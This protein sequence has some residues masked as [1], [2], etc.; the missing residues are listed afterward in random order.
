MS[1]ER[2][3][4]LVATLNLP[5]DQSHQLQ[6]KLQ[7]RFFL[8]LVDSVDNGIIAKIGVQRH[9]RKV[10]ERNIVSDSR[11]DSTNWNRVIVYKYRT[12]SSLLF[13][14]YNVL[15]GIIFCAV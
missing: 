3:N 9:Q 5:K 14:L 8:Y 4:Y 10:L 12:L 7:M 11:Q 6:P 13:S 1:F 15:F 2:Q